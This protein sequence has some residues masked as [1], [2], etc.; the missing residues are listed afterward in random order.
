M[1]IIIIMAVFLETKQKNKKNLSVHT[2]RN[3]EI[4]CCNTL[5]QE[6]NYL[7]YGRRKAINI[8]KACVILK[9]T[10]YS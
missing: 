2:Q 9:F 7:R 8:V 5:H 3:V 6:E 10:L 4:N 1:F